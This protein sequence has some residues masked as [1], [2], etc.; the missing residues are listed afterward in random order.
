MN[1]RY[2]YHIRQ[3]R[4][5]APVITVEDNALPEQAIQIA[6]AIQYAQ[7]GETRPA[8]LVKELAGSGNRP[9]S[10]FGVTIRRGQ[11]MQGPL[12]ELM[13]DDDRCRCA[14]VGA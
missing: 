7:F 2:Q 11:M 13:A 3:T 1:T 14:G 9:V 10:V 8:E 6:C 4:P 12:S 5:G